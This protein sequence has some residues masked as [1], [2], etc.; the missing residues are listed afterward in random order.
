MKETI[1][2]S[3]SRPVAI[4]GDEWPFI[5]TV[6]WRPPTIGENFPPVVIFRVR[7]H[8]DGRRLVY[9]VRKPNTDGSSDPAFRGFHAGYLVPAA[10]AGNDEETIRAIRR[11]A[12]VLQLP[13]LAS[14]V[15]AKLP[16]K[17]L[18]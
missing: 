2:L 5:V 7:Q 3:E 11:V 13:F 17:E 15:I 6:E 9:G 1:A 14:E 4:E 12:G 8:A 10:P 18:T 16:V